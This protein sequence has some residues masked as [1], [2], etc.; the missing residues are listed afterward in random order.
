MHGI[1]RT[2]ARGSLPAVL[3]LALIG[4]GL[5]TP[6]APGPAAAGPVQDGGT[7]LATNITG[8]GARVA[9]SAGTFVEHATTGAIDVLDRTGAV[10]EQVLPSVVV[11]GT[12]TPLKLTIGN[13]GKEL[14]VQVVGG[15]TAGAKVTATLGE[16]LGRAA[17]ACLAKGLPAAILP[18]ILAALTGGLTAAA[19]LN[20]VGIVTAAA[21]AGLAGAWGGFLAGCTRGALEAWSDHPPAVIAHRLD[22]IP[23]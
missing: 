8:A 13:A 11:D 2:P 4:A 9:L 6:V 3:A 23:L 15:L 19:T 17:E 1:F 5:V 16:S 21:L 18:G 10:T 20:P 12:L 22:Q 14:T 7:F